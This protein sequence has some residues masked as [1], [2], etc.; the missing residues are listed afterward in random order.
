MFDGSTWKLKISSASEIVIKGEYGF[1]ENGHA[2]FT[3]ARLLLLSEPNTTSSP[4]ADKALLPSNHSGSTI[5]ATILRD[6]PDI[7]VFVV[8]YDSG[9]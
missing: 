3:I 2:P 5:A 9:E 7:P 4:S 1:A 8:R 6:S